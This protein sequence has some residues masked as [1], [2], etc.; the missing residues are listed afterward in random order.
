MEQVVKHFRNK[1]DKTGLAM[2][3]TQ[4]V[5]FV[6][7]NKIPRVT[8][9]QLAKFLTGET[10]LAQ[11]AP[12]RQVKQFQTIGVPRLGQYFIDYGE[13]YKGLAGHNK[14]NTGFLVAVENLT[15]RLFVCPSKNKNTD[16]WLEAIRLFVDLTRNVRSIYS[17]RDAVATSPRFQE[18]LVKDFG[19]N[20][21]FLKKGSKAYLAERYIRLVKTKLSQAMLYK[22]TKNWIQFVE[23]LM[24]AYNDDRIAGTS[25]KRKSVDRANFDHLLQQI[26]KT[27]HPDLLFNM[28]RVAP[29][30]I[31]R[32]NKK[33]FKFDLGE[34]VLLA[35]TANWKK[36]EGDTDKMPSK[37]FLKASTHGGFGKQEFTISGRR[38]NVRKGHN[39][40]V[41]VYSLKE[42]DYS[43]NFYERELKSVQQRQSNAEV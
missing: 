19:L 26:Y 11:F 14:G 2:S 1:R 20:W 5:A 30:S 38:L 25:Y 10:D 12:V 36:F 34:K 17:D 40:Y 39:K 33:I 42:M 4:L 41:P 24:D 18:Q 13:F 37:V 28:S 31:E 43:V 16:S 23:P 22:S 32:W 21:Y 9:N 7:E 35:R 3:L 8:R 29:F 27:K 6:K 15:N